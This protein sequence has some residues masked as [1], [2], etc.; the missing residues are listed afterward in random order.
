[1]IGGVATKESLRKPLSGW[2]DRKMAAWQARLGGWKACCIIGWCAVS[3]RKPQ[4]RI[5]PIEIVGWLCKQEIHPDFRPMPSL[6]PCRL[7][8]KADS[9]PLRAPITL[10]KLHSEAERSIVVLL[11][12]KTGS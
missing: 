3:H 7:L 10:E 11:W 1:V 5:L 2:V 9:Q 12:K 4:L 8:P 6:P